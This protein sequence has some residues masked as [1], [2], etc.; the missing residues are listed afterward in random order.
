[1]RRLKVLLSAYACEPGKGSEPGVGWN[2]ARHL[3]EHHEVWV[4]TRANS[5]PAIEAELARNPIPGLHFVY[6]DLP[7]WARFWKRGQRG[8]QL[9]YYLWQLT[10]IPLVRRLHQDV[11]FDVVQHVTFVKYWAPSALAFL[12]GVPF[13][14]GPVGGGESAP[15]AF[16]PTL[17]FKGLVYEAARTLARFLGEFDPLVRL[18]AQ[19]AAVALATTPETAKRLARL[20]AA[21][22]EVMSQVALSEEEIDALGELPPPES[23]PIRF[24]SVGRLL[25]WKGFHLGIVAFARSGLE[26]AEYWIVGDGPERRRLEALARRLGVAGRVRFWGTLPRQEVLRL[27]ARVHALVHP[28]LHDSGGWVCLEAMAAGRPVICLNLGGPGI[29][30]TEGTGFKVDPERPDRAIDGLTRAMR[31]LADPK[32]IGRFGRT[33]RERVREAFSWAKRAERINQ[34]YGGLEE[35]KSGSA[36]S[37]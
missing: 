11:G 18:T 15:L 8:V 17:G 31:A 21:R 25:A 33:A 16:W 5:R 32:G 3:A 36:S 37:R 26:G 35:R 27:L 10:A 22:I 24:L 6:H 28:S 23:G 1:M 14:W 34:L 7:P 12:K 29:Q 30:V 9:Y 2:L 20:G 19:R 4:L 13:V